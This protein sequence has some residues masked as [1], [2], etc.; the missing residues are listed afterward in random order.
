[1]DGKDLADFGLV[2][3]AAYPRPT[4]TLLNAI[5]DYLRHE[6]VR[7]VN[8][9]AVSAPTKLH[10]HVR[11]ALAGLPVPTTTYLPRRLLEQSYPDLVDGLGLPFVLKSISA[12]GG[13][14]NFLVG[15]ERDFVQLLQDPQHVNV[16]FLAQEFIPNDTTYRFLVLGGDL[17]L[18]MRQTNIGASYSTTTLAGGC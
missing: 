14:F 10:Q 6:R 13:R 11:F 9:M 17:Q 18:V 8:M 7:T 3:V 4:A 12:S 2:Q 1:V 15:N 16:H 5:A